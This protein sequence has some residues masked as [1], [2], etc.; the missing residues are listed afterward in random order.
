M[1]AAAAS[2][3][4]C[5]P[6]GP[7]SHRALGRPP[8][9]LAAV[10]NAEGR[11]GDS[12]APRLGLEPFGSARS[13]G[14]WRRKGSRY[15]RSSPRHAA[16][17]HAVS[18]RSSVPTI[19]R[20][21]RAVRCNPLREPRRPASGSRTPWIL[22]SWPSLLWAALV[23]APL[24]WPRC[25]NPSPSSV[26]R[27]KD[28]KHSPSARACGLQAAPA[29]PLRRGGTPMHQRARAPSGASNDIFRPLTSPSSHRA[30]LSI[31]RSVVRGRAMPRETLREASC[32]LARPLAASRSCSTQETHGHR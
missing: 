20:E 2:W 15:A 26:L 1:A 28:P 23:A 17:A 14:R 13:F 29:C 18:S 5:R 31:N 3:R 12:G 22:V 11:R 19:A 4:R 24:G 7:P 9:G 16:V 6:S 10:P 25:S 8:M 21:G 30:A 27:S 32:T